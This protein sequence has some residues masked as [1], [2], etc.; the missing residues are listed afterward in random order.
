MTKVE[1]YIE[2]KIEI[3]KIS[4]PYNVSCANSTLI[5]L[6]KL[7][8]C[9]QLPVKEVLKIDEPTVHVLSTKEMQLYDFAISFK[10]KTLD[11][12]AKILKLDIDRLVKYSKGIDLEEIREPK[13]VKIK[14]DYMLCKT[15]IPTIIKNS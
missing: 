11:E 9:K 13:K 3:A 7:K 2:E 6:P 15:I 12:L 5:R 4:N 14:K 8:K 1:A 10:M